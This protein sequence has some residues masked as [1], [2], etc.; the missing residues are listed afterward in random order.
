[1]EKREIKK[2]VFPIPKEWENNI[3]NFAVTK[4]REQEKKCPW[5]QYLPKYDIK[6][7]TLI[8]YWF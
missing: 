8:L 4:C 7:D 6:D 1:M 3:P 2:S 5:R